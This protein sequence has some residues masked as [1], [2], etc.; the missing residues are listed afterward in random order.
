MSA[1]SDVIDVSVLVIADRD[2]RSLRPTVHSVLAATARAETLGLSCEVIIATSRSIK[3]PPLESH[4]SSHDSP[5]RILRSDATTRGGARNEAVRS[6]TGTTVAMIDSG[7]MMTPD[8]LARAHSAAMSTDREC[9]IHAAAVLSFGRKNEVRLLPHGREDLALADLIHHQ[10]WSSLVLGR[11]RTLSTAPFKEIPASYGRDAEVWAW[12]VDTL[13]SGIDHRSVAQTMH[14]Q[15]EPFST[16]AAD[17]VAR[18][19]PPID[20]T[21]LLRHPDT[22]PIAH[23]PHVRTPR[24]GGLDRAARFARRLPLPKRLRAA[25]KR[26]VERGA[27]R[28]GAVASDT[29]PSAELL[30]MLREATVLD[31]AVSWA[32]ENLAQLP[33]WRPRDDGHGALLER[34]LSQ[35]NGRRTTLVA[36]PWLGIGGGGLVATNYL[37]AL[38]EL[39]AKDERVVLLTTGDPARTVLEAVPDGVSLLQI[40]T[41]LDERDGYWRQRF[42]AQLVVFLAPRSIISVNCHHITDAMQQFPEQI[43]DATDLYLTM[44]GFDRRVSGL[45]SSPLTDEGMRGPLSLAAGI[46]T[47]N[48][49]MASRLKEI[50]T[51]EH[52]THVHLQPA[53]P[54]TPDLDRGGAAYSDDLA[55]G[56][57]IRVLWP[58]R[59]DSEKRPDALIKL[60]RTL[61]SHGI[62]AE[63]DVWGSPVVD[64]SAADGLLTDLAGA[65]IRYRGPYAGGLSSLPLTDYHLLL[66]TSQ[67]EGLPLVLVQSLLLGLPVVATAV[68]GVPE[69]V[70]DGRTGLLVRG[71]EDVEGMVDAIRC[72]RSSALRRTLIEQGYEYAAAQHSWASFRSRVAEVFGESA[73]N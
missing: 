20:M 17:A 24:H 7:D 50:V 57:P 72:L 40:P 42:F 25:L 38:V 43:T 14:L 63:I 69:I 66:L 37:R 39:A 6:A 73:G 4:M 68:G 3:L 1:N 58:H 48:S 34:L 33:L 30:E 9:I 41:L 47:D 55:D 23:D 8:F 51:V 32:V 53:F 12:S 13:A 29:Y 46:L 44:F 10:P 64:S 19:L 35:G 71:P 26:V 28:E 54:V 45:P 11:R 36:V 65:G 27:D 56:E 31:P 21:G 22:A 61:N 52:M 49:T 2:T 67:T 59:L 18:I 70:I 16:N 15:R 62:A 5:L 60:A